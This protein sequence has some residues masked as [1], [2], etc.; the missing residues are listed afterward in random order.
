M[1]L[2]PILLDN[3]PIE[4]KVKVKDLGVLLDETFSW[5]PHVNKLISTAYYKLK[6]SYRFKNF[7]TQESKTTL[8]EGYV[9][10]HFNYC[11]SVYNN[12]TEFLKQKIQK[13][14]N[15]C[16][17]FIFGLRK[18]DHISSYFTQLKTL[19]MEERRT[20]HGLTTMHKI[21]T[22][23]APTYLTSKIIYHNNLHNYNTRNRNNIVI[24][25]SRTVTY[26]HSY[27]PTFSRLYNL[28]NSNTD[29][30]DVTVATFRNHAKKYVIQ[31]RN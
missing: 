31:L 22:N 12:I 29:K 2:P 9:L 16:I 8:C 13:A 15:T 26:N 6:F 27:F 3:K 18:Y 5:T 11:D 10:A 4:R 19:N 20:V 17:R 7:L 14:Q 30:S 1:Q 25:L 23:I 24:R 21:V 28:I